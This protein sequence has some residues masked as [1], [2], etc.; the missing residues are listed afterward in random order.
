MVGN[1][2]KFTP[3]GGQ[4][5]ITTRRAGLKAVL[6]ISDTGIPADE[7]PHLAEQPRLRRA[8]PPHRRPGKRS[9]MQH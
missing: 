5:T 1:A 8:A 9:L 6:R 4:V 2:L 3:P 7:L